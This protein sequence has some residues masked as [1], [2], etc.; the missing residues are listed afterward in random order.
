MSENEAEGVD[1]GD[2]AA[3]D[4]LPIVSDVLRVDENG[5]HG[6][7]EIAWDDVAGVLARGAAVEIQIRAPR[8]AYRVVRVPIGADLARDIEAAWRCRRLEEM[9]EGKPLAGGLVPHFRVLPVLMWALAV[10]TFAWSM[11]CLGLT[12]SVVDIGPAET[13]AGQTRIIAGGVF[14]SVVAALTALV[15]ARYALL[16]RRM[17][18]LFE[19]WEYSLEGLAVWR[20]DGSRL[21]LRP[22]AADFVSPRVAV[23]NGVR[24]PL[25][26]MTG[27]AVLAPAL[28][29]TGRRAE[30]TVMRDS[31]AELVMVPLLCVGL[32]LMTV[33]TYLVSPAGYQYHLV[34][35]LAAAGTTAIWM[36]TLSSSRRRFRRWFVDGKA[37]ISRLGW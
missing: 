30:A 18:S 23:F 34:A 29:Y 14:V 24:V 27:A 5:F 28:L 15:L 12:L 8:D 35:F 6:A 11:A 25:G 20:E 10:V 32:W 37:M 7:H 19:R 33:V 22:L 36:V 21:M 3:S 16:Y 4:M 9:A 26:W 31:Y 13:G 1:A 17:L 2:V